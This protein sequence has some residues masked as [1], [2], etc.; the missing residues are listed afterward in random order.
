MKDR[1]GSATIFL[2]WFMLALLAAVYAC[3][4]LRGLWPK[5]SEP[6]DLI[7]TW[8][9]M[10]GLSVFALVWIRL[11]AR[12]RGGTPPIVPK[13]A[14]WQTGLGHA[15]HA[16]LYLLMI[17][18]PIAGWL[19][20]SAEGKPIPFFGLELPPLTGPNKPLAEQVEE[21]HE[22]VGTIGY[23]LI[24]LHA[25]AALFHHYIQKDN[26]FARMWMRGSSN[27]G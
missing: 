22:T 23:W 2:H 8:H 5:G 12:V 25:A 6:R 9:F 11:L 14:P 15:M 20:L 4:E 1:F 13:P 18:M 16:A 17:C 19:I 7:K 3:I 21:I 24:G 10:L 27:G 26:T